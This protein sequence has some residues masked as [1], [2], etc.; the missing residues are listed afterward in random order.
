MIFKTSAPCS[1]RVRAQ[2]GPAR[3]RVR[4]ST[5]TP[6][7]GRSPSGSFSGGLSPI[8]TISI[9]GSEAIAAAC[10]C[11]A[12]SCHGAHHA[13]G[14]LRGD[15]RLLELERVPLRH[16]L[17]H[18]LAIFRHAEHAEGGGT[19]VR[20][21]AVE[22]APAAVL[23]RID[24]HHRVALGRHGRPVHLHV[25]PAAERGGRLAGIDR[26]L[27][28]PPGAQFPQIGDGE[29]DRRERGG[30]GLADAERRRQDRIGAAGDLDRA[31]A[32]LGPAGDRQQRAQSIIGHGRDSWLCRNVSFQAVGA[33]ISLD[34]GIGSPRDCAA[35]GRQL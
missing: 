19:M 13:P 5:R 7:N 3:T 20:E 17:A 27:L 16:R 21:I 33:M 18:R 23:G 9:S 12:H 24:A 8:L 6:D 14:A 31:G 15:D 28:A 30:T 2:V 29:A 25:T 4:S 26:D 10:G 34:R 35:E 11:W 1:A 32:L 22:I